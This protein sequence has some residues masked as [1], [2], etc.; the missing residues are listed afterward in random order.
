M[1]ERKSWNVSICFSILKTIIRFKHSFQ[2]FFIF[3]RHHLKKESQVKFPEKKTDERSLGKSQQLET[4]GERE[5]YEDATRITLRI[6]ASRDYEEAQKRFAGLSRQDPCDLDLELIY[7]LEL[8]WKHSSYRT[9]RK[10]IAAFRWN[11]VNASLLAVGYE[12]RRSVRLLECK[13]MQNLRMN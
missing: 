12:T 4:I 1:L 6:L 3:D 11:P 8:L 10:A 13:M 7:G 9:R 5:A 2:S